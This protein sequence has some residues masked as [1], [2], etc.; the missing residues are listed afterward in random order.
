MSQALENG[1]LSP[2][3]IATLLL[4]QRTPFQ[5]EA[6]GED[7]VRLLHE[8]LVEIERLA[9]GRALPRLTSR[10]REMLRRLDAFSKLQA[11]SHDEPS[12]R[13]A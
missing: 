1:M 5:V 11:L 3:E 13:N 7:T 10:G 4:I 6:L 12:G 2:H 8:Q 9:T